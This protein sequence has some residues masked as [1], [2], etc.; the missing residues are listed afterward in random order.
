[1]YTP[2]QLMQGETYDAA[3]E[4]IIMTGTFVLRTQD[5]EEYIQDIV[6]DVPGV[7]RVYFD[8]QSV[9]PVIYL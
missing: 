8:E 1:M 3:G 6:L 7:G 2:G 4:V 9:A 5:P